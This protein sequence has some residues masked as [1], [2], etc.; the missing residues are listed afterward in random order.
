MPYFTK[1]P[2]AFKMVNKRKMITVEAQ[3]SER[4]TLLLDMPSYC[5]VRK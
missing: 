4:D 5:T 1:S 3:S 2:N